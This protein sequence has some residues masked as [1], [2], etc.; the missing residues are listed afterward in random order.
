MAQIA[1][2]AGRGMARMANPQQRKPE[3]FDSTMWD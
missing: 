2:G 3:W 1:S